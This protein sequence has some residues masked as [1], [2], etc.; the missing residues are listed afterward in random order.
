LISAGYNHTLGLTSSNLLFAWGYNYYGQLG[1]S[2]TINRSSPV[3]IGSGSFTNINAGDNFS[4]IRKN[5]FTISL[6]GANDVGQI[7]DLT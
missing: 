6:F 7:G 3:Q 1:N 5:D 2:S 4:S